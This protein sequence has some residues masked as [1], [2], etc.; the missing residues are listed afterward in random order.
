MARSPKTACANSCPRGRQSPAGN[1]DRNIKEADR[2]RWILGRRGARETIDPERPYA[3]LIERERFAAGDIGEVAT[4]FLTNRECPWR[5]A[6]CD[7][8]R[9]TL[10]K[11]I[12]PGAI[13][14][15]IRY[16][17]DRLGPTRQIKLYNSGSFFDPRAIPPEDDASIATIVHDFERVIVESHPA[18]VG[19]RCL[20]FAE[21]IGG[22]LEVAMG[23]ETAHPVVLEKLN[24]RMTLDQYRAA[25]KTLR[26]HG[27]A[28]R[29]FILIQPPFMLQQ[30]ALL[31]ACRSMDFAIECGASAITLIP[32]RAG[33]GAVDAL[34]AQGDFVPP[35]LSLLENALDYGVGLARTRIFADLWDFDR[36]LA[37]ERCRSPRRDR[38]AEM[39]QSQRLETRITCNC[40]RVV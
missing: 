14:R 26:E 16:S 11:S 38:L 23:L 7:L 24:K 33:N 10:T 31:W 34:A 36:M 40:E 18:L 25:A 15:Q 6:M 12:P 5:C 8:W 2:D 19:D 27:I 21:R 32:T 1:C 39:N 22:E 17:L 4:V 20:R 3:Y 35:S 30:E 13:P 28:L 9:Y 37:C 29:A